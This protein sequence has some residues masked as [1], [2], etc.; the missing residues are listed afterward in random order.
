M[1]FWLGRPVWRALRSAAAAAGSSGSKLWADSSRRYTQRERKKILKSNTHAK[2]KGK[3]ENN[4]KK[5]VRYYLGDCDIERYY[6]APASHEWRSHQ[7]MECGVEGE[8][9]AGVSHRAAE[10]CVF[11]RRTSVIDKSTCNYCLTL[12]RREARRGVAA[13]PALLMKALRGAFSSSQQQQQQRSA[14]LPL[15]CLFSSSRR[16]GKTDIIVCLL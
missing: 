11:V 10:T 6:Y 13:L 2:I 8:A 16:T 15:A 3:N 5:T 1:L 4:K 12:A 9:S 7:L 14:A